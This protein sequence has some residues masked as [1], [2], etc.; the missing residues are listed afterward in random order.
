MAYAKQIVAKEGA[1]AEGPSNHSDSTLTKPSAP[2]LL[3][4]GGLLILLSALLGAR[5]VW[6]ETLL[7]LREG[8]QMIGFSLAHGPGAFLLFAPFATALWLLAALV[9]LFVPPWRRRTLSIWYWSAVTGAVVTLGILSIPPA[10]WQWSF[11]GVFAKSPRAPDLMTYDAAEGDVRTVRGYLQQGVPLNAS[12]YEGST[13][14]FTAAAGGSLST[15]D[16]LAGR[17]ADLNRTNLYGDSPLEVA[18]EN[19]HDSVAAFLK[20]HGAL[21]IQGTPEQR[22]A[23]SESIVRREI[24]QE[25]RLRH[26]AGL[27]P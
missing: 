27:S 21:Q 5:I 2:V 14:A 24:E 18:I 19:H 4:I 13:A 11:I 3:S 16:M 20:A 7:T 17:G 6:E 9:V 23:A 10:F 8:P 22:Q 26:G 12:N 1:L 15:L 25:N